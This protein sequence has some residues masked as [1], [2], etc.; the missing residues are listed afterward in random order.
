LITYASKEHTF[1]QIRVHPECSIPHVVNTYGVIVNAKC[2]TSEK[3]LRL[4]D[5]HLVYTQRGLQAAGDLKP[6]QDTV[7]A[8]IAETTQCQVV[9][10]TKETKQHDYF[11]LNCLN[12]QVL[13][14][15]LKSSTFEKLH[16]V[17]AFWMQV[18]GRVLG[19]KRA[20]QLGDYI[21]EL[22]QKMNLI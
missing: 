9:S 8:D 18:M 6:G 7:Y 21:A 4:T 14:S 1:D 13:A 5:G 19:I 22:V 10:V 15:G 12:S 17:P 2:A 11:G 16:S 20:S 3:T